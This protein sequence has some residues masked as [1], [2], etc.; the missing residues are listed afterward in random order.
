MLCLQNQR[1]QVAIFIAL[2]STLLF[3]L[4]G[5]TIN[6]AMLVHEKINLQNAADMAAYAGAAEQ[7]RILHIMS[8][9]NYELRK[10][11][12]EILY[13]TWIRHNSRNRFFP[14]SANQSSDT[15]C[16]TE[17][18]HPSICQGDFWEG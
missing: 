3:M 12:K 14:R 1:G 9:K 10:V 5:M 2:I 13:L 17:P 8:W 6:F 18:L 7:S 4:F 11:Y 15:A 16:K